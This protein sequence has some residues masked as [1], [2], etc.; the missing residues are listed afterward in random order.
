MI[1]WPHFHPHP[2]LFLAR[3]VLVV[4]LCFQTILKLT[5]LS[6]AKRV[7]TKKRRGL[8]DP[9]AGWYESVAREAGKLKDRHRED[10]SFRPVL[11]P[12][13]VHCLGARCH[14]QKQ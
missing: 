6:M 13:V 8:E 14:F 7:P 3:G 1:L 4:W 10:G 9:G 12:V 11:R 5:L 2:P